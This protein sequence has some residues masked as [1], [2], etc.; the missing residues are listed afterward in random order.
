MQR[1]WTGVTT[2]EVELYQGGVPQP[3]F[4]PKADALQALALRETSCYSGQYGMYVEG[5]PGCDPDC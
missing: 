5:G 3:G 1:W 2:M 4:A